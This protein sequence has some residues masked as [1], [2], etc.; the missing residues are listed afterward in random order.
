MAAP[1][2]SP[3]P[4]VA[5]VAALQQQP[6]VVEA[7][8]ERG[9]EAVGHRHGSGEAGAEVGV[10]HSVASLPKIDELTGVTIG[11]EATRAT[12][13]PGTCDV[14]WPRIWRTASMFSPRPCM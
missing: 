5:R 4:A 2:G 12:S 1:L 14:D 7:L 8:P 9:V 3:L 13:A 11:P 10:G 6:V